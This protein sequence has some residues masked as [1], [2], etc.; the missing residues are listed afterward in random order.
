MMTEYIFAPSPCTSLPIRGENRRFPI[1]RVFLIGQNYALHTIEMG[2]D[3]TKTKP[4][5]FMKPADAVI[6]SG[7]IIPYPGQTQ[8]LHHEIE[9]VVAI[10][11]TGADI[12]A[13]SAMDHVYGYAAGIDLTRRDLQA[14]AKKAGRPWDAAKGFDRSAPISEIVPADQVADPQNAR[15]WLS[16]NGEEPRQ[17]STTADMIFDIPTLISIASQFWCLQP[18]DL[19]FS[20][21]PS[22][23]AAIQ[24]GDT[25]TGGIEGVADVSITIAQEIA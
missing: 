2:G 15:I 5:I 8:D 24:P 7:Q 3:P 11:K 14:T 25:V 18:G 17:D 21:T 16:V 20:G 13:A 4:F 1:R 6:E 10:G 23:V 22:G 9:L 19:I 12:P